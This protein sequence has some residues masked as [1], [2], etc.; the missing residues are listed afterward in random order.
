MDGI[1]EKVAQIPLYLSKMDG[2]SLRIA[3]VESRNI[4]K[5]PVLF[6]IITISETEI[7]VA[8]SISQDTSAAM[9]RAFVLKN[10][11]SILAV[12]GSDY[13]I[14]QPKFLQ[15]IDSVLDSILSGLSQ[16]YNILYN[17]YDSLLAEYRELKR[18]NLEL[19]ASNRNLTIQ[20]AQF[21]EEDKNLRSQLSA[22]QKYSDDALMALIEEWIEVHSNS[23]DLQEFSKTY[24]VSIP[25]VE[26]VLD[27]MVSMGYLELKS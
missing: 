13:Q 8:Y 11:A 26:Q 23:I 27:K 9:R 6:H 1:K 20:T 3:R 22:L 14:D 12:I 21:N 17:K 15:Y 4:H 18:L 5:K 10:L 24:L 2:K 25:R 7:N 16:N 19:T